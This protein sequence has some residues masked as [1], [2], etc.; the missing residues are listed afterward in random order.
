MTINVSATNYQV[1]LESS[2]SINQVLKITNFQI[3]TKENNVNV[4]A[5]YT[6]GTQAALALSKDYVVEFYTWQ[7]SIYPSIKFLKAFSNLANITVMRNTAFDQPYSMSGISNFRAGIEKGLDNLEIQIQDVSLKGKDLELRSLR[8]PEGTEVLP[9]P[10]DVKGKLLTFDDNLDPQAADLDALGYLKEVAHDQTLVGI[11]TQADPLGVSDFSKLGVTRLT[12]GKNIKLLPVTGLGNVQVTA[13]FTSDMPIGSIAT[14][15]DGLQAVDSVNKS[16]TDYGTSISWSEPFIDIIKCPFTTAAI[17][18]TQNHIY[19]TYDDFDSIS[20]LY[21]DKNFKD[22][23]FI[24]YVGG[25]VEYGWLPTSGWVFYVYVDLTVT[26]TT[27]TQVDAIKITARPDATN[28]LVFDEIAMMQF[29]EGDDLSF[30]RTPY[31]VSSD[32]P[33]GTFNM[34]FTGGFAQE[35]EYYIYAKANSA[36]QTGYTP[37]YKAAKQIQSI[38]C[39]NTTLKYD[40]SF[41]GSVNVDAIGC[42][43]TKT[44]VILMESTSG[45]ADELLSVATADLSD[46]E[47]AIFDR[48]SKTDTGYF[49]A[50]DVAGDIWQITAVLNTWY[51]PLNPFTIQWDFEG[52]SMTKVASTG[53]TGKTRLSL[54]PEA[55]CLI[56]SSDSDERVYATFDGVNFLEYA[57]SFPPDLNLMK[58]RGVGY[59]FFRVIDQKAYLGSIA[60]PGYKGTVLSVLAANNSIGVSSAGIFVKI[61]D[62]D[63]NNLII[64]A[65]DGLTTRAVTRKIIAG[66]NVTITS[67]GDTEGTGDVTINASGGGGDSIFTAE[68]GTTI[69]PQ[70]TAA[71]FSYE[72]SPAVGTLPDVGTMIITVDSENL[73][74]GDYLEVRWNGSEPFYDKDDPTRIIKINDIKIPFKTSNREWTD[75]V[76]EYDTASGKYLYDSNWTGDNANPRIFLRNAGDV[77]KQWL[78]S[79]RITIRF[80]LSRQRYQTSSIIQAKEVIADNAFALQKTPFPNLYTP[81]AMGSETHVGTDGASHTYDFVQWQF[82]QDDLSNL[83]DGIMFIFDEMVF[84]TKITLTFDKT[85]SIWSGRQIAANGRAAGALIGDEENYSSDIVANGLAPYPFYTYVW[86]KN[87]AKTLSILWKINDPT[88]TYDSVAGWLASMAPNITLYATSQSNDITLTCTSI[89][90]VDVNPSD[91]YRLKLYITPSKAFTQNRNYEYNIKLSIPNANGSGLAWWNAHFL[92]Y[93]DT[94]TYHAR[95]QTQLRPLKGFDANGNPVFEDKIGVAAATQLA[96]SGLTFTLPDITN[97]SDIKIYLQRDALEQSEGYEWD[98]SSNAFDYII[99]TYSYEVLP[100]PENAT[101]LYTDKNVIIDGVNVAQNVKTHGYQLNTLGSNVLSLAQREREDRADILIINQH[102]IQVDKQIAA[103]QVETDAALAIA[104]V[105]L[106]IGASS[107]LTQ[108]FSASR[109]IS[110]GAQAATKIHAGNAYQQLEEAGHWSIGVQAAETESPIIGEEV[111]FLDDL[112]LRARALKAV[113]TNNNA[114][115]NVYGDMNAYSITL[116]GVT[117]TVWPTGGGGDITTDSTLT[118]SGSAADPLKVANPWVVDADGDASF[119]TSGAEIKLIV[120]NATLHITD[121]IYFN[122]SQSG[123]IYGLLGSNG[124]TSQNNITAQYDYLL[125]TLRIS[126]P[127]NA[128]DTAS[129]WM[130]AADKAKLDSIVIEGGITTDSTLTGTGTSAS[131]LKVANPI[132][133]NS[134][135]NPIFTTAGGS[136]FGMLQSGAITT[137]NN[138]TASYNVNVGSLNISGPEDANSSTAGWMSAADKTKLDGLTGLPANVKMQTSGDDLQISLDGG[139]TWRTLMTLDMVGTNSSIVVGDA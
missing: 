41:V 107:A 124:V 59:S 118:G 132:T 65:D 82:S 26:G 139:T 31:Y 17:G 9:I 101:F 104:S 89:D 62:A 77:L 60:F 36:T 11:G 76:I 52:L 69:D 138:I 73:Q 122:N 35:G 97:S 114:Q 33:Y 115:V 74:D 92:L 50:I 105:A 135:G 83:I 22:G 43:I 58:I 37:I 86:I 34:Y 90:A 109:G 1:F 87:D 117:K 23:S 99:S 27:N 78:L 68:P 123:L 51:N 30:F 80:N 38:A 110:G 134:Q 10:T 29:P 55:G 47:F 28:S 126:G 12:A 98:G 137:A 18:I 5:N 53:L 121:Y 106:V 120:P 133:A 108:V 131:P 75:A 2:V 4:L 20:E 6:N 72:Y 125:G 93:L 56:A 81:S 14:A 95:V 49:Y 67:T 71:N 16:L 96:N 25:S 130:S 111:F 103:L 85:N 113:P 8:F 7:L 54:L 24:K 119:T 136:Y 39:G 116:G 57:S 91:C 15:G 127:T 13:D 102:L 112:T 45:H 84:Q 61:K 66:D 128:T 46:L 63:P 3:G 19:I 129:G 40:P 21:A 79:G 44:S 48:A 64:V 32:A 42:A 100:Y 94:S 70:I 88:G